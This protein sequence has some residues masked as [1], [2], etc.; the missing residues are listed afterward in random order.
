MLSLF[1]TVFFSVIT[2]SDYTITIE[3]SHNVNYLSKGDNIGILNI[4]TKNNKSFI[5]KIE[6]YSNI[7]G[8][9]IKD[10]IVF[11]PSNKA[12]PFIW[13]LDNLD[14]LKIKLFKSPWSGIAKIDVNG[15]AHEFDLYSPTAEELSIDLKSYSYP[16]YFPLK[17]IISLFIIIFII[18]FFLY[19]FIVKEYSICKYITKISIS[20]FTGAFIISCIIA[21]VVAF[22]M[23]NDYTISISPYNETNENALGYNICLQNY[24]D[25]P[26][27]N[28][29]DNQKLPYGWEIHGDDL[30]LIS[31]DAP[32]VILEFSSFSSIWFSFV[33]NPW[34]AKIILDINGVYHVYDLYSPE[35]NYINFSYFNFW[36]VF[37]IDTPS[38]LAFIFFLFLL[39]CITI[40]YNIQ[41]FITDTSNISKYNN[42]ILIFFI[43]IIVC[44]LF[45]Y[46]F[47]PGW[48]GP[49]TVVQY[50]S[51][52]TDDYSISNSHPVIMSIWWKFL[53]WIKPGPSLYLLQNMVFYWMSLYIFAVLF[54]K[55]ANFNPYILIFFASAPSSILML[56][57]IWKDAASISALLFAISL[58][59]YSIM[60]HDYSWKLTCIT[61]L[62]LIFSFGNRVNVIPVVFI[63][64][65]WWVYHNCT[66]KTLSQKFAIFLLYISIII[67]T[68][69]FMTQVVE[70][71]LNTFQFLQIYDLLGMSKDL[72]RILL[73][74]FIVERTGINVEN[75]NDNYSIHNP[76][77]FMGKNGGMIHDK[78]KLNMLSETWYYTIIDN[79]LSY[80]KTRFIYWKAL[81]GIGNISPAYI[82]DNHQDLYWNIKFYDNIASK[83]YW[84]LQYKLPFIFLPWIY[85]L[86]S[87]FS[88]FISPILPNQLRQINIL[89]SVGSML[90]SMTFFFV[91]VG[92]DFRYMYFSIIAG[93]IQLNMLINASAIA[94][95]HKFNKKIFNF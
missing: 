6:A 40:I 54:K 30:V 44:F 28:L 88:L 46:I 55:Y 74:K 45:Y 7:N 21:I 43:Y 1:L 82:L 53:D 29:Y 71:H 18:S 33:K 52:L 87:I 15:V 23:P 13:H 36:K 95:R 41:K 78:E 84:H 92:T 3:H 10:G 57:V 86:I 75:L 62:L 16:I 89:L 67:Y 63:L 68:P 50:I 14:D 31:P 51:T 64:L 83:F 47:Y 58:V 17:S 20:S 48:F 9:E 66:Y 90:Y 76:L 72:N 79:P 91:T 70:T 73:P 56:A 32:P 77:I 81:L 38:S 11:L 93:I 2:Q 60:L 22:Y 80:I 27:K 26:I 5:S 34:G 37:L 24:K 25:L 59:Y 94:L 61:I 4:G 65:F 35:R 39:I 12:R 85:L 42:P 49:D 19:D 8:W 69:F